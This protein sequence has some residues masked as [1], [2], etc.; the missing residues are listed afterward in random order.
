[1]NNMGLLPLYSHIIENTVQD[2][3]KHTLEETR[4]AVIVIREGVVPRD[5]VAQM[6]DCAV[7]L[8]QINNLPCSWY[9]VSGGTDCSS[10]LV[11]VSVDS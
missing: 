8:I 5:S 1:M 4:R 7:V 2:V 9:G 6:K 10:L 11:T 3:N